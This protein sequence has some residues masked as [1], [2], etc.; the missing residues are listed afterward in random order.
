MAICS[1][2]GSR[3]AAATRTLPPHAHVAGDAGE[4]RAHEEEDAATDALAVGV[5]REQEEHEEHDDGEDGQCLE[6]PVEVGGGALLNG[7]R[8]L[9]HAVRAFISRE[10]LANEDGGHPQCSEGDQGND[11]DDRQIVAT[12]LDHWSPPA[13]ARNA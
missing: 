9:L 2:P 6:L 12:Q 1:P 10:N 11:D 4:D 5:G 8:D 3:A 7:A 13:W